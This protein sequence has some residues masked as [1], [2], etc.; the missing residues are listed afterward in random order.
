M[1]EYLNWAKENG[2]ERPFNALINMPSEAREN[3]RL[4]LN[5]S[6]KDANRQDPES[7]AKQIIDCD[8]K[9]MVAR[10]HNQLEMI[11][12]FAKNLTWREVLQRIFEKHIQKSYAAHSKE[13][14]IE[15]MLID[16][17]LN[18]NTLKSREKKD[19][20]IPAAAIGKLGKN[21]G[22]FASIISEIGAGLDDLLGS[23]DAPAINVVFSICLFLHKD[24]LNEG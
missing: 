15:K 7:E 9:G 23:Q 16:N 18:K 14:E 3:L 11:N 20:K 6:W 13:E 17:F 12:P 2:H 5:F 4:T 24:S 1:S 21:V 22:L 10:L 19:P 8:I